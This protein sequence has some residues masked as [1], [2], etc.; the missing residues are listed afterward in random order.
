MIFIL[1]CLR[2]DEV[3][4]TFVKKYHRNFSGIEPFST[5]SSSLT[6]RSNITFVGSTSGMS[7]MNL[8][9]V[10]SVTVTYT[11]LLVGYCDQNRSVP[12]YFI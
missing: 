12:K 7:P 8:P 6:P 9:K 2:N 1:H 5:S 3:R 10:V 4:K 11:V